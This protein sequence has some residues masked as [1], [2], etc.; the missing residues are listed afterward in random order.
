MGSA[1]R[2]TAGA[3]SPDQAAEL[4]RSRQH[5]RESS[6]GVGSN[7]PIASPA[8]GL[9]REVQGIG[10]VCA[11]AQHPAGRVRQAP[12]PCQNTSG[13]APEVPGHQG[14]CLL[15]T[16]HQSRDLFWEPILEE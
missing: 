12:V 13:S 5:G 10:W 8:V 2:D 3:P 4:H 11:L 7:L 1:H 15:P 9:W 16:D 14:M 6:G